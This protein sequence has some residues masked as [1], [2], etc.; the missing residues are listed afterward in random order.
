[1]RDWYSG[2]APVPGHLVAWGAR[3]IFRSGQF[4]LDIVWNRCGWTGDTETYSPLLV[5][6]INGNNHNGILA[7]LQK[8]CKYLWM[9][10]H[11][12]FCKHY[13]WPHDDNLIVVAQGY[14][15]GGYVHLTLSLVEKSKAP[16][17]K[18]P[19][20][21]TMERE[22][23]AQHLQWQREEQE[24]E[25]RTRP[26]RKAVAAARKVQRQQL[27][28][29]AEAAPFKRPGESLAVGDRIT[30]NA[31]QGDRDAFVLGIIGDEALIEYFM[32]Q[33]KRFFWIIRVPSQTQVRV[34]SA[35]GMAKKWKAILEQHDG[36]GYDQGAGE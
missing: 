32:P 25:I 4:P 16:A 2:M 18:E 33:G 14:P 5:V 34:V 29:R 1:M 26:M 23:Q 8:V 11:E 6:A 3:A 13:P 21:L 20:S 24:R 30:I 9:D 22:R 31:N 36:Q 10:R 15:S 7:D 12:V 27:K 35:N 19:E 28:A 17:E